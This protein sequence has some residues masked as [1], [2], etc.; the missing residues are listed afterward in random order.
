MPADHVNFFSVSAHPVNSITLFLYH[1][2]HFP[3]SPPPTPLPQ[4]PAS[5]SVNF[6]AIDS[7][8]HGSTASLRRAVDMRED[9]TFAYVMFKEN[10]GHGPQVCL[11]VCSERK[12]RFKCLRFYIESVF[13]Q[14]FVQWDK[15]SAKPRNIYQ[16][17]SLD[18][19]TIV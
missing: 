11:C 19:P 13:L 14:M 5:V 16:I 9:Y 1:P 12:V 10:C 2:S 4:Y 3:F 7:V 18:F 8:Y 17:M 15:D 6:P